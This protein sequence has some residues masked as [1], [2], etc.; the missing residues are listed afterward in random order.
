MTIELGQKVKDSLTGFE[1][2]VTA[3]AEYLDGCVRYLVQPTELASGKMVDAEWI[4]INR[5]TDEVKP[6]GGPESAPPSRDP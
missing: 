6:P 3:K 4:D 5:L 2:V 1:G